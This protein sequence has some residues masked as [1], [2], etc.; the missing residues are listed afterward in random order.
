MIIRQETVGDHDAVYELV[1]EAFAS[2]ERSDGNEQDLVSALRESPAFIPQLSLVA[3]ADGRI[4]GH[5]L[6]TKITIGG[7]TAVALAPL[8]VR[9]SHQRMGVGSALIREGHRIAADLGY[10]YSVVLGHPDY[11]PRFGYVP[12]RTLSITGPFDVPD[13][14][15][16]A[17]RLREDAEAIHGRVQYDPAFGI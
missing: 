3:V 4:V 17:V 8:A 2:A 7:T 10:D 14:V 12:A 9:P 16:M 5:I 15:Y 1:K 13:E 6:F 11:Y